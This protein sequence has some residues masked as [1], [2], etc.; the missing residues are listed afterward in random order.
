M[1]SI[2]M[3]ILSAEQDQLD[4]QLTQMGAKVQSLHGLLCY[5]RF[6]IEDMELFYVYNINMKNQFFLQRIKPYPVSAGIFTNPQDI[7]EYIRDDVKQFR[8]AYNSKVFSEFVTVNAELQRLVQ[9]VEDVFLG[10][11]VPIEKMHEISN[12]ILSVDN[13]LENIKNTSTKIVID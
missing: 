11:N 6:P 13:I 9:D 3:N 1:D 4:M 12:M 10:Y 2:Y 5:I 7:V 8:N